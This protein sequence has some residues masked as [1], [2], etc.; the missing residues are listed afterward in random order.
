MTH[1]TIL[2]ILVDD[3]PINNFLSKKAIE[4]NLSKTEIKV[5]LSPEIAL[6]YL[7]TEFEQQKQEQRNI[8]LL[9]LNMPT[10]TG[11]EFLEAFE[12]FAPSLKNQF[13]IY[14]LSSSIDPADIH[15]AKENPLVIDF[16][17]KPLNKDFLTR[18]FGG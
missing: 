5:F 15:R 10:L 11:W 12:T 17:E 9:D 3:D 7:E 18:T 14:I 8:I 4:M 1:E 16:I 6:Q 2:F 13:Q